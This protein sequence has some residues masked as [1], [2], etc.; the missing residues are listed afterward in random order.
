MT[1]YEDIV[2]KRQQGRYLLAVLLDPDKPWKVTKEQLSCV[3][4][5]F[6][7]G[8]TGIITDE[9]IANVRHIASCPIILFPGNTAQF[10]AHADGLLMLSLL[11]AHDSQWL[12]GHQI[13]AAR[14]I[15]DS[16]I[17]TI[18]LGYILIDGGRESSV[19]RV[20]K[21]QPLDPHDIQTITDVAIAGVLTGKK[22]IYL[23]AGSGAKR[24]V[25]TAIIHAVK[26]HISVPLIV[27]GGICDPQ[28]MRR[29]Y[30]AGADIVV[31]GNYFEEHSERIPEFCHV[32]G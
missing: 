11:N 21:T 10:N 13:A 32:R 14:K 22:M 26:S 15:Y 30:E 8:S 25:S 2:N 12:I 4:Y 5:I 9:T 7:G 16:R 18:P 20:S 23:E 31:I 1:L 28:T 27:G 17:E 29:C 24:P 6:L 19:A 3:D